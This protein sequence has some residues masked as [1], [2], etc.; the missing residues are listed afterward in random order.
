MKSRLLVILM[1]LSSSVYATGSTLTLKKNDQVVKVFTMNELGQT[2]TLSNL[3]ATNP[4]DGKVTRFQGVL[5]T[6]LLDQVFGHQWQR[7]EAIKFVAEDGYRVLIPV[8]LTLAH[9]GL[10]A[11]GEEGQNGFKRIQ[12]D[13]QESVDPGPYWLVWENIQDSQAKREY[14]LSW[15]WQLSRIE[16]TDFAKENPHSAPPETADSKAKQGFLAFQQHCMK[17]HAINSDGGNIGPELNY[18][19][20]VTEYWHEEW[21]ARF[22]NDPKSVRANSKMIPF[23]KDVENRD[24]IID[25]I[26]VYLKAMKNK[27]IGP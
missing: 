17:C 22:I 11:T 19:A 13:N 27:K 15:P 5:L 3:T 7:A 21:L 24:K 14:W 9:K 23:Y 16:L 8:T 10:I 18:P 12:R 20:N 4:M 26:L 6:T 1:V 25:S 2:L